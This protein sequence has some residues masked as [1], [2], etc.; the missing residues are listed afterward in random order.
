VEQSVRFVNLEGLHPYM[1]SEARLRV[2]AWGWRHPAIFKLFPSGEWRDDHDAHAFHVLAWSGDGL[3]GAARVCVHQNMAGVHSTL[4]PDGIG[5]H[6][7]FAYISRLVVS[8]QSRRAGIAASID[9]ERTRT[10][11]LAGCKN[12]IVCWSSLS[13]P[14]RLAA[15]KSQ[16]FVPFSTAADTNPL[17]NEAFV[18]LYRALPP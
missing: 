5:L 4:A 16:G 18:W 9:Q 11:I 2:S 6:G 1:E 14:G 8:P 10:A 12:M 7:P 15:V 13:G 17:P 3:I